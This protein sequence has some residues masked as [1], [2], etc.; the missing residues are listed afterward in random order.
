MNYLINHLPSG[1]KVVATARKSLFIFLRELLIALLIGGVIGGFYYGLHWQ[2]DKM[3]YV[4]IG[5]GII[6]VLFFINNFI[7]IVSTALLVSTSKFLFKKDLI[8]ITVFQTQL[9]NIDGIEV[10]YKTP[11]HRLFNAGNVSVLTRNARYELKNISQP[12]IFASRLNKQAS[13]V[14][15]NKIRKVDITFGIGQGNGLQPITVIRKSP[16]IVAKKP[17]RK[18]N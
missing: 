10:K 13:I 5:C 8:T 4:Y 12:D 9:Q 16:E 1:E 17:K 7:K 15:D 11:L 6:L 2:F 18:A 14:A 3:L